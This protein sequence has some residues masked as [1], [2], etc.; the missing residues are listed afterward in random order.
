VQFPTHLTTKQQILHF[1]RGFLCFIGGDDGNRTRV[2]W[3]AVN[4]S[5]FI[6][7]FDYRS[8]IGNFQ[9]TLLT[10]E[11]Y[12]RSLDFISTR[13]SHTDKIRS[14]PECER[15]TKFSP[16]SVDRDSRRRA[17]CYLRLGSN[18]LWSK[19]FF[20]S[21]ESSSNTRVCI[22]FVSGF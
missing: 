13:V 16:G 3:I 19:S 5:T 10:D 4:A 12:T 22:C 9:R 6:G 14:N 1:R 15:I 18:S 21:S 11:N 2:Q 17:S 8:E 7:N 20:E